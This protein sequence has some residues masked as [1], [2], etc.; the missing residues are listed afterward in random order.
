[1]DGDFF[2]DNLPKGY[3]AHFYSNVLHDWTQEKVKVLLKKSHEALNPSGKI[4]IH[5]MHLNS[6]KTGPEL[7]IDHSLYLSVFTEGRNYSTKEISEMLKG[8]GFKRSQKYHSAGGYSAI[9][10]TK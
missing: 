9:V 4:I 3:D 7:A 8:V 1:M 2:S 5:G 10:A 6:D